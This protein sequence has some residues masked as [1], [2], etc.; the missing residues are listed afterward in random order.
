MKKLLVMF[1][2]LFVIIACSPDQGRV[3]VGKRLLEDVDSAVEDS[4]VA[5]EVK[6]N[7][8]YG[9]DISGDEFEDDSLTDDYISGD[10]FEDD[11]ADGTIASLT[12]DDFDKLKAEIEGLEADDLGGLEE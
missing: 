2:I 1:M 8:D 10:D 6:D 12:Q 4:R 3:N 5:N 11:S 7:D 9:L